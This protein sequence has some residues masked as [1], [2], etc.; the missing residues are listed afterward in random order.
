MDDF[1]STRVN[2]Y[3]AYRVVECNTV[4]YLLLVI[5]ILILIYYY[6]QQVLKENII[7]GGGANRI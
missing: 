6:P 7:S 1:V 2:R 4:D 5:L 3:C